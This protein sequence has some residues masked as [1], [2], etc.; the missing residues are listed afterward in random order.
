MGPEQLL[1]TTFNCRCGRNH[2]VPIRKIV[3][4]QHALTQLPKT[5]SSFVDGRR[6]I[7]VADRRTFDIAGSS[8]KKILEKND[9][10][11]HQ[12]IAPDS[13]RGSPVCE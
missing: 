11:V 6:I 5:L 7:L 12:I 3:Y 1:D 13:H 2:T 9:W 8:A 4:S 10:S